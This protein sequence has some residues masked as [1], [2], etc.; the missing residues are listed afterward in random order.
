MKHRNNNVHMLCSMHYLFVSCSNH[1]DLQHLEVLI[2]M[3][4]VRC[5]IDDTYYRGTLNV[6]DYFLSSLDFL[7]KI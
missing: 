7:P 2:N 6:G 4:N 5:E 1:D 3:F